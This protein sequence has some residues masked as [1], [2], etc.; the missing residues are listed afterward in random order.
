MG[1]IALNIVQDILLQSAEIVTL[2]VGIM[3]I[4]LSLLLILSP[5]RFQKLSRKLNYWIHFDEKLLVLDT[6]FR[7]DRFIYR[8]HRMAGVLIIAG[9][10]FI[11]AFLFFK[12]DMDKL[13]E[14][15]FHQGK[16]QL[17]NEVFLRAAILLGKIGGLVG[18][19][20]GVLLVVSAAKIQAI[21]SKMESGLTT[22]PL[23]DKL[24]E[25]HGGLDATLT[26]YP[27]ILGLAGL[28]ASMLLAYTG[29]IFLLR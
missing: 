7:T 8:H 14:I 21:E 23:V 27:L 17:L 4:I 15:F 1:G 5:L 11:L 25:F 28:V 13:T 16:T 3:G 24:N 29:A 9:S 22:Q 6:E 10:I 19:V 2:F 26:R 18:V 12:L 20:L